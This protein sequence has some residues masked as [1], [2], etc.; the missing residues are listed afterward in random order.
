MW[1][2]EAKRRRDET[3]STTT[4]SN[5]Q[6][7]CLNHIIYSL[8]LYEESFTIFL[9]SQTEAQISKCEDHKGNMTCPEPQSS[10]AVDFLLPTLVLTTA[11]CQLRERRHSED[12]PYS[13]TTYLG[14]CS[15]L[16]CLPI[17]KNVS[18]YAL[19]NV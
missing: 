5:F 6:V 17:V 9:T 10:S 14:E 18:F 15:Q 16:F 11:A 8:Y 12:G 1:E 3:K 19:Q 2:K 4:L 7:L 13:N